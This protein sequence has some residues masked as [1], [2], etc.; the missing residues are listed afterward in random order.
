MKREFLL[1]MAK[2]IVVAL[3]IVLP[4]RYFIFQPF[5]VRGV[6]MEPNFLEGDYL[7]VDQI[8]YRL[9]EPERGDV[10][11]FRY[12]NDPSRRYIKRLIALPGERVVVE[13]GKISIEREGEREVLL[14]EYLPLALTPGNTDMILS[15][16]E[17]FV[18]GDNRS[19]SYDSRGWGV[20]PEENIIGKAFFRISLFNAF[21]RVEAPQY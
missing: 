16:G 9:H 15:S 18:L 21:A 4:I 10:I 17:Y 3:L 5:M 14:E 20:L 12:P 13:G 1:E 8:S 7:I 2:V 19:S 6:S 11:V